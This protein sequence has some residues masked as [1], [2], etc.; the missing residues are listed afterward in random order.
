MKY[1][2]PHEHLHVYA[3]AMA[4]AELAGEWIDVWP[5]RWAVRNQLDRAMESII[6]NLVRAA[7]HQRTDQG[8]YLLECSLRSVLEGAAC[9]DVAK[10]RQLLD[11]PGVREAKL[12]LQEVARMEVGLRTAWCAPMRVREEP[13]TYAAGEERYFNHESL[14]VYMRSLQ[15]HEVLGG[16]LLGEK[17]QHRYARRIDELSTSL[18]LNIA[19]GNGRYSKRDHGNFADA[20]ED[21][22]TR[23]AGYLDLVAATWGIDMGQAKGL[24]REVMAMLVGLKGFLES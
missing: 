1:I 16:I 8:T 11:G 2:L 10:R 20:A 15:L 18:S 23:L 5:P 4:F 13:E 12:M 7:R 21:A 9:L 17:K 6:T 19:E 14:D 22:A 3:K 24:L